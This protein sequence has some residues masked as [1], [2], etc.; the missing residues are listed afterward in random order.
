MLI[1]QAM[2]EDSEKVGTEVGHLADRNT[3]KNESQ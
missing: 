3:G 1:R 2:K